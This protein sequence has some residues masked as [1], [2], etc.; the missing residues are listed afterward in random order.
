MRLALV[1]WASETGVGRELRDAHRNLPVVS[2]FLMPHKGKATAY[3][4]HVEA[5]KAPEM[6]MNT[7]IEAHKPDTVLTWEGP[8]DWGF[9]RLWA[10]KGIRWFNVVH[11]DWFHPG[12]LKELAYASL[13][14]P[15][16]MCRRGLKERY[17][18]ASTLLPVPID[19][20]FLPFRKRTKAKSFVSVY[21]MG[22]PYSRRSIEE[23]IVAW[24]ILGSHAP[25]LQIR[26]QVKPKEIVGA[27][28]NNV[29]LIVGTTTS[30]DALY[31]GAD[32]AVQP[33]RFEGVGISLLE[34]QALGVP[35]ITTA[36]EPMSDLVPKELQVAS[37]ARFSK[38][39][40][41]G[42]AVAMALPN[43]T[44]L[45]AKVDLLHRE[46]LGELST[47]CSTRVREHFS[48]TAL[49]SRWLEVLG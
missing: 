6:E 15:N 33:S 5:M 49:L 18:L 1:G 26:A 10:Q 40:M 24:D 13:I 11:W 43:V 8:G 45:A 48:W 32:V 30:V 35:V 7:F 36:A 12:K 44:D 47:S 25:H 41:D 3:E 28:P 39:V 14:A 27:L 34:A 42:H 19:T 31:A 21:G 22:G 29:E 46:G 38:D 17:G 2:T 20:A 9:P 16:E 23:V 4:F 37:A